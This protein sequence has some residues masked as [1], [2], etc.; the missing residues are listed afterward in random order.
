MV[1][2]LEENPTT[3]LAWVTLVS[4]AA[5]LLVHFGFPS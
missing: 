2:I 4:I 1:S 3:V 5:N